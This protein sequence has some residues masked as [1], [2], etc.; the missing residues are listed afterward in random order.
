MKKTAKINADEYFLCVGYAETRSLRE[1]LGRNERQTYTLG[2]MLSVA[3]FSSVTGC[4]SAGLSFSAVCAGFVL[5]NN[6]VCLD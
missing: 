3:E 5:L 6:F 4:L 2:L 1:L